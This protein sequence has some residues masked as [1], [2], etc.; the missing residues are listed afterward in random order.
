MLFRSEK[1]HVPFF[2]TVLLT[3]I[4]M[5]VAGLF[6]LGILGQ[7]VSMSTLMTFGIVC[8][9]ILI[10]HYTRPDLER[11]FKTPCMPWVPLIGGA[12]CFFQMALLPVVTWL[13]FAAWIAIGCIVYFSYSIKNSH[14]QLG[15]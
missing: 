13:Q 7:L 9:G 6:P 14:V 4:G 5:I 15:K 11:P 1:T 10:L 12:A 8:T 3:V 2:T